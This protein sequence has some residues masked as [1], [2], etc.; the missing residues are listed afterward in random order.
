MGQLSIVSLL[1]REGHLLLADLDFFIS[2]LPRPVSAKPNRGFYTKN[3]PIRMAQV[4]LLQSLLN[5]LLLHIRHRCH[6][7]PPTLINGP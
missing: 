1:E 6:H 4:N 5:P 2:E 7:H 3:Q